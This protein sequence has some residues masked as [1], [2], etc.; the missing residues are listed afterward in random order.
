MREPVGRPGKVRAPAR[1]EGGGEGG[2]GAGQEHVGSVEHAGRG[3]SAGRGSARAGAGARG[4]RST[5]GRGADPRVWGPE[6]VGPSKPSCSTDRDPGPRPAGGSRAE[7]MSSEHVRSPTA[8]EQQR[9]PR[10]VTGA[11]ATG[12]NHAGA[13]V[14]WPDVALRSGNLVEGTGDFPGSPAPPRVQ[15]SLH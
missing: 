2:V 1:P 10:A 14:P 8:F 5:W 11:P 15:R 13:D 3:G 4:S 12:P 6:R 7:L 9:G